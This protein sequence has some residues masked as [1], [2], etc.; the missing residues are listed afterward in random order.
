M[1]EC[2]NL[3]AGYHGNAV[4]RDIGL[5]IQPGQISCL[6]GANGAGKTTI[7]KSLVGLATRMSGEIRIGGKVEAARSPVDLLAK[8]VALVP[9]GRGIFAGLTVHENLLVGGYKVQGRG[10]IA[11][12]A[13]EIYEMFPRLAERR[14]ISGALLSGGEQQMLTIGRALMSKPDYLLLDEPSMGLS[15]LLVETIADLILSLADK[16]IGV[17]AAEQNAQFA[18]GIADHGYV[19]ESG[20]IALSGSADDLESNSAVQSAYLGWNE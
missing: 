2:S 15:P 20:T 13:D 6:V 10:E 1:L 5:E 19:I 3:S 4:V 14:N 12:R 9:E 7:L 8:G 11:E 17:L 16:G 18:F